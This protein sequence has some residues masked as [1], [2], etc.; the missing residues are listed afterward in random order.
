[1]SD[2]KITEAELAL[3]FKR[4]AQDHLSALAALMDEARAQGFLLRWDGMGTDNLGRTH[5]LNLRVE[6]HY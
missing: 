2:E 4:D 5:A 6:K 3:R 1:M